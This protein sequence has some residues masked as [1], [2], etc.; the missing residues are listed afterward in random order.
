VLDDDGF[1]SGPIEIQVALDVAGDRIV[2]DFSGSSSQVTGGVNAVS[3]ITASATRYVVRCVVQELLGEE[4]PAGGGSMAAVDL[5][6]PESSVVNASLPSSVAAANVETS[7]RI[8]DVLLKAFGRALPDTVPALSQGT[9]NNTT[10]GGVDP[11]SG[12]AF[13]YYETV[14]GGMG[15]GPTGAGL[16][17]VHTHMSNSLNTPVEALEHAYP[18]RVTHYSI[19]RGT[20]GAGRHGGGD[21]LRRDLRIL[22]DSQVTLLSERR[23]HAPEGAQG[24]SDGACGKNVLIREG[25]EKELPGKVTFHA[26]AGDIISVRSPGGGGWGPVPST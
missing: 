11:R 10:V 13:A 4:V 6:L 3:A 22:V 19:R 25:Q 18:F 20:G 5:R 9:M 2:V 17:G 24:G 7:L 15:A 8:T 23:E 1:G 12:Q 26:R 16:S 14:G 21:G